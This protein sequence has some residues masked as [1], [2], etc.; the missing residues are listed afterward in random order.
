MQHYN[1]EI[2]FEK[3]VVDHLVRNGW[4]DGILQ[5]P[6]EQD[7]TK[8]WAD[9]LYQNNKDIDTLNGQPLTETEMQQILDK[10]NEL[11][12]PLRLNGFINGKSVRIT[13]DNPKDK[14]HYGKEV[15]LHIYDRIEIAAG[16]STYQIAEQPIFDVED[17]VLPD[18]RGD[19]ML[20]INGMPLFHVELKRSG[21]AVQ[22][23]CNQIQTYSHFGIFSRGIYSLVQVF[24][25][26]TP[27]EMVYFANPGQEGVF[28]D[29]FFFHWADANNKRIDE[30]QDVVRNFFYIPHAHEMI[31]FFTVADKK[32]GVL[33]VMRSYQYYAAKF[34]WARVAER[35][36]W[37]HEDKYGGHI[38][39]TT[40]S[41]KTM[42]S[43][44]AA[45]LVASMQVADKVV[46]LVDRVDLATQSIE[47][48][49]SFAD[50]ETD[51]Q[52]TKNTG[53]LI[54]RLKSTKT[55]DTLI[56]TSI[57]KMS[58]VKRGNVKNELDIDTIGAKKLV[59]IVDECH[60]ST[61]GDMMTDIKNTFPCAMFFGFTGTPILKANQRK[62]HTTTTLFGKCRHQYSIA[63]GINDGNVLGFDPNPIPTFK[64]S[65]L[66]KEVALCEANAHSEEE[67][68][69]DPD[70]TAIYQKFMDKPMAS[71]YDE[72]DHMTEKGIEEYVPVEQYQTDV[73]RKAVVENIKEHWVTHSVNSKFH[74]IFAT[75]SIKEA[76]A[77]YRLLKA[78]FPKLRATAIFDPHD[79]FS[80]PTNFL[81][82]EGLKEILDDYNKRFDEHYTL[83]SDSYDLFRKDVCNRL[84]HKEPYQY[85]EKE[86]MI[87]MVIVVNQLLTGFDSK[88]INTLY[89]DKKLE[90]QD[91]IQAF[92]RTNRLNC[93]EKR[94]GIIKY[95]RYP[96]TMTVN[97]ERAIKLY[98]G[99]EPLELFVN[100]LPQNIASMNATF[101]AIQM[102]FQ[103]AHIQNFERL[104][105]AEEDCAQFARHFK[106]LQG[107]LDSAKL[108]GFV[109]EKL[110]Y[111]KDDGTDEKVKLIFDNSIYAALLQRYKELGKGGGGGGGSTK[112][113]F[114]IDSYITEISTDAI[115]R[116]Y[117]NKRFKNFMNAFNLEGMNAPGAKKALEDLHHTF[118]TLT[119]SEQ[120]YAH[121]LIAQIQQGRK[122]EDGKT[123]R[124][125]IT[126]LQNKAETDQIHIISKALGVDEE[127][128][129]MLVNRKVNEST[130]N[131]QNK[132][133]ELKDSADEKRVKE[134]METLERKSLPLFMAKI[135]MDNLLRRFLFADDAEREEI[136]RQIATEYIHQNPDFREEMEVADAIISVSGGVKV[137]QTD[138]D[139]EP[140]YSMVADSVDVNS[141]PEETRNEILKKSLEG[142]FRVADFKG[143]KLFMRAEQWI[144]IYRDCVELGFSIENDYCGF[145]D[146]ISRLQIAEVPFACTVAV[147]EKYDKGVFCKPQEE[148]S[149]ESYKSE[150]KG[151]YEKTFKDL[152]SVAA[153][154][155]KILLGNIPQKRVIANGGSQMNFNAPVGQAIAHVDA[156]VNT[157]DQEE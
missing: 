4:K 141:L 72:D 65:H 43:F 24:S 25:A 122:I 138:Y 22:V 104:P 100:K 120:K 66:R 92:S 121:L 129:R 42:T 41:G 148:W 27:E 51:V 5:Y 151:R 21:V 35:E 116:D 153:R 137:Y 17:E 76:I 149:F 19:L 7:L 74:A 60:R 70:K 106:N 91:L 61:F 102:I 37:T 48:Y 112:V 117:M 3:D 90:Y 8:N 101:V 113:G 39:H 18:R 44:K 34:I 152:H 114:P 36:D 133:N 57:Q 118:A 40:G 69:E 32:D 96:H 53:K 103:N 54:S 13:R 50:D 94:H 30:W 109:W 6:T 144:G 111:P 146:Q 83:K 143:K 134:C 98:S 56:V 45:Q 71:T 127:L 38:W 108:Q 86:G 93:P 155:H 156:I 78:E 99:D 73:H 135:R 130:I 33:K 95:Y 58:N 47:E 150:N 140:A 87:D 132:F 124:D 125:L 89:L 85:I 1:D 29:R 119:A 14:L 77:Y 126:E 68:F 115:D 97:I 52:D 88:W 154:F 9:I 128:L 20:L 12:T 139:E 15:D 2:L 105:D 49:R 16:K 55:A 82:I 64:D 10:V 26:M 23:A 123:F 67:V 46:F 81:K 131:E 110:E 147:L 63:C 145:V 84:A 28:N 157:K 107:Y 62:G 80:N 31:G 136:A 59:L 75:S 142:L 79:D 11:Q